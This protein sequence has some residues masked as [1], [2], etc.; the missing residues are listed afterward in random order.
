MPPPPTKHCCVQTIIFAQ[1]TKNFALSV[2]GVEN[3]CNLR[4]FVGI[5]G[6]TPPEEEVFQHFA[7]YL[8][9]SDYA[10]ASKQTWIDM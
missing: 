5:E 6:A 3:Q 7:I 4:L 2:E 8:S 10:C 9:T 1:R